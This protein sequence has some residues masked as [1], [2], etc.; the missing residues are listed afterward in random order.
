M[1]CPARWY[2]AYPPPASE[3]RPPARRR[4]LG[5][6]GLGDRERRHGGGSLTAPPPQGVGVA[7]DLRGREGTGRSP[8]GGAIRRLA[9]SEQSR[10]PVGQEGPPSCR[11]SDRPPGATGC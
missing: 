11:T 5:C 1:R 2:P 4:H 10:W 8:G 9:G 6:V 7:L 3:G